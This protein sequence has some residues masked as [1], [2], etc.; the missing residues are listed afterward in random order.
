MIEKAPPPP[1]PPTVR[2]W[3]LLCS[4]SLYQVSVQSLVEWC[5]AFNFPHWLLIPVQYLNLC[6]L[7]QNSLTVHPCIFFSL[8]TNITLLYFRHRCYRVRL[9]LNFDMT[10][11]ADSWLVSVTF[12]HSNIWCNPVR[13]KHPLVKVKWRSNFPRT[14]EISVLWSFS[15]ICIYTRIHTYTH[16]HA[17]THTLSTRDN[18]LATHVQVWCASGLFFPDRP[19]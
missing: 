1:P 15:T 7:V 2:G 9:L 10:S 6:L 19:I 11:W 5:V 4:I 17:H 18:T 16:T 14:P 12:C 8:S 3:V 13:N